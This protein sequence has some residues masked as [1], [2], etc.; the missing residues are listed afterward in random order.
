M[1]LTDICIGVAVT[2]IECRHQ[3]LSELPVGKP[4]LVIDAGIDGYVT[5]D[6]GRI[7]SGGSVLSDYPVTPEGYVSLYHGVPSAPYYTCMKTVGLVAVFISH[8]GYQ[9]AQVVL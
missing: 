7:R 8:G 6:I 3:K 2:D 9:G 4:E 5:F 1:L